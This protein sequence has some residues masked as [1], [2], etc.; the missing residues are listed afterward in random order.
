MILL[1]HPDLHRQAWLNFLAEAT[2]NA[3]VWTLDEMASWWRSTHTQGCLD[4]SLAIHSDR[5]EISG[6]IQPGQTGLVLDVMLPPG[7]WDIDAAS[8]AKAKVEPRHS[9]P[10]LNVAITGQTGEHFSVTAV[11]VNTI[12]ADTRPIPHQREANREVPDRY[13]HHLQILRDLL[14]LHETSDGHSPDQYHEDVIYQPMAEGKYL[15]TC[16]EMRARGFLTAEECDEKIA[17][18]VKRLEAANYGNEGEACWGLGFAF[19]EGDADEPY[20]ITTVLIA[21]GLLDA[22]GVDNPLFQSAMRWLTKQELLAPVE[23]SEDLLAPLFSPKTRKHVVNVV[24]QWAALLRKAA[25]VG[26]PLSD[27]Y[28]ISDLLPWI[29]RQYV[30]GAG[31]LYSPDN[32][33]IDL[34]HQCYIFNG[35][36]VLQRKFS[37]SIWLML[38]E[39]S[40]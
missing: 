31:F 18:A 39:S 28:L 13:A 4:S 2:R 27:E 26:L 23:D 3:A 10:V 19:G 6:T 17:Q 11:N 15:S 21:R 36:L 24:T 32:T 29:L 38:V 22:A 20:V 34:L 5:A 8:G 9:R 30:P 40:E 35:L 37:S 12:A 1:N 16:A 7:T 33:R 14:Q 25:A